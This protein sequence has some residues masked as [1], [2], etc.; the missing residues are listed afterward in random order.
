M[1]KLQ[2]VMAFAL[3]TSIALVG[4]TATPFYVSALPGDPTHTITMTAETLPNGQDA[5][6][7]TSHTVQGGAD[8]TG[9]YSEIATIPGPTLIV[10]AGDTVQVTLTNNIVGKSVG[11]N[12]PGLLNSNAKA[13]T[14]ESKTYEFTASNEGT[15][16][17]QNKG[18]ARLGLFGAIIVNPADEDPIGKYVAE[19][20]GNITNANLDELDR[21]HVLFMVG[22]TFWGQEINS[23]EQIPLWTNPTLGSEEDELVRFHVIAIGDDHTFHMHAHRWVES[24]TNDNIIDTKLLNDGSRHSFIVQSGA[25]VG[26]GMW[27]YHC[28][29]FP[30]MQSGM[31]GHVHVGEYGNPQDSVA[32]ANP[33]N[34]IITGDGEALEPGVVTFTVTDEP[35]TWFESA[36]SDALAPLTVTK[37]LEVIR[38]GDYVNFVMTET[39]TVHTITSLL[40]PTGEANMPFDQTQ[41]YKGGGIVQLTEPGLYVFTCKVHPYMFGGVI[42]DDPETQIELDGSGGFEDNPLLPG[43]LGNIVDHDGFLLLDLGATTFSLVNGYQIPTGSDLALRLAKTYFVATAPE[44]WRDY[45][46]PTW[47][48]SYPALPV[49]ASV[50]LGDLNGDGL[51]N[52]DNFAPVAIQNLDGLME[53][54]FSEDT[55]T[56]SLFDPPVDSGVGEV[57]VNAQFEKTALKTKPGTATA[58]NATT[59]DVTKKVALPEINMNNPHNMWTDEDQTVIYQTEWFSNKLTT[60]DRETGTLISQMK[61]G[62]SPSHVMTRPNNDDITVAL[63]GEEGVAE[64]LATTSPSDVNRIIAMQG[65]GLDPTHPHAQW[66][67]SDGQTMI[68]PNAFTHDATI[69]GFDT[70]TISSRTSTGILPLATAMTPDDEFG[71]VANLLSSTITVVDLDD[72]SKITDINLLGD[73]NPAVL[74]GINDSGGLLSGLGV[75]LGVLATT[76]VSALP[77]QTPISPD[78]QYMV[79]ANTLTATVSIV[80]VSDEDPNNWFIAETLPCDPGC[81][82][83]QFGAK[84]GDGYYAYVSSKFANDLI[85]IDMD[86]LEI[87]GRILLN[88]DV[89][90]VSDDTIVALH[91]MGGQGVMPIPNVYNGWVQNLPDDWK[92]EL[93]DSQKNPLSP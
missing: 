89:G 43:V 24:S 44:N 82:G 8:I 30:H 7:M 77:I 66:I 64:I 16:H 50:Y 12:I 76:D 27:Q 60:F 56:N 71:A 72:G 36:R 78:G 63:N 91:G 45:T 32:G 70:E 28:H 93:S 79:T 62:E 61:V 49:K 15:F 54:Y 46:N 17:Y 6:N 42:V 14:G 53:F 5:Y 83:V 48:P 35:G 81:H 29:V 58:V 86:S 55:V 73:Y 88:T 13:A 75:D 23:G 90:T 31:H 25:D 38:P 9:D 21:E 26:D 41:A 3:V 39:D 69:Y 87:D 85:V 40:W 19:G 34:V 18:D 2:I 22:S 10:N 33:Y 68:T 20:N 65:Y 92:D 4:A 57:W 52:S 47:N 59:W 84:S 74:V 80:D 11:F 51:N 1:N 67:S 37:A